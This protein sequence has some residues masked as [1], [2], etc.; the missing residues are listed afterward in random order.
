[1]TSFT[2]KCRFQP[3]IQKRFTLFRHEGLEFEK[4]NFL[5]SEKALP[6]HLYHYTSIDGLQG[7]ITKRALWASQIHFLNDTQEFDY[8]VQI[9]KKILYEFQQEYPTTPI[10]Q[11]SLGPSPSL[12]EP[13]DLLAVFYWNLEQ[14]FVYRLFER[15]PICI[16]S[17][18]EKRD[19]PSQWRGYCPPGGGYSIGFSS[20]LLAKCLEPRNL[21]LGPC[22]YDLKE[23][24]AIIKQALTKRGQSVLEDVER[25]PEKIQT[26]AEIQEVLANNAYE[27]IMEFS[28]IASILKHPSFYEEC[29]WRIVSDLIENRIKICHLNL[30]NPC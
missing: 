5:P 29:E 19:L 14:E 20:K 10:A 22:I 2:K 12:F 26:S 23:Q 1:M 28:Q 9:L 11:K 24:E 30:E 16:F 15:Y 8:A 25:I 6:E 21:Y 3:V 18:S 27:F 13:R 17:L 4:L 7:I